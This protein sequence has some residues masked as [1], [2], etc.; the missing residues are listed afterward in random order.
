MKTNTDLL[1]S[2][3]GSDGARISVLSKDEAGYV[4]N[5][6]LDQQIEFS[7][8]RERQLCRTSGQR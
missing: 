7:L 3:E 2:Y 8:C 5:S 4:G 1:L 6:L